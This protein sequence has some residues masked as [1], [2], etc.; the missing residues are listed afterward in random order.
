MINHPHILEVIS[1][2]MWVPG[3]ERSYENINKSERYD[4]MT[5][6]PAANL[7]KVH[8]MLDNSK[9]QHRLQEMKVT[10]KMKSYECGVNNMSLNSC[11]ECILKFL[12][13]K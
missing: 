11:L 5:W 10:Q 3:I 7:S 12:G 13:G 8:Q 6:E 1:L 9:K 2:Q 4:K